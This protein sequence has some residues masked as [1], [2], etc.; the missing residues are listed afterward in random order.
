MFLK[1]NRVRIPSKFVAVCGIVSLGKC[2]SS[3]R[4]AGVMTA[5]TY[6]LGESLRRSCVLL[7]A[8]SEDL[9]L[10]FFCDKRCETN[11]EREDCLCK[12]KIK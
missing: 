4:S 12:N 9:P 5:I 3:R 8:K 1:R 2:R 7:A 10:Q 11:A 6:P